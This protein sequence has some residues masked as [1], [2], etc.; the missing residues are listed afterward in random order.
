MAILA[1]KITSMSRPGYLKGY[2]RAVLLLVC[3]GQ[4]T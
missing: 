1:E 3:H 4:G 2:N